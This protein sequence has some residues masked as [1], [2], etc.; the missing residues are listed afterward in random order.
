[1][2]NYK[3]S[4]TGQ[5]SEGIELNNFALKII[6]FVYQSLSVWCNDPDRPKEQAE[7]KLN[8]QLCKFLDSQ[9]R[10]EFSMIR[11]DHEEYQTGRY[12]VDLSASPAEHIIIKGKSYSIYEPLLVFE[13]KRLPAPRKDRE[14]EYITGGDKKTGGIQRFKLGLHGGELKLVAMIGYLQD[15]TLGHWHSKI[16]EWILELSKGESSDGLGWSEDEV[17]HYLVDESIDTAKHRSEHNRI[18]ENEIDKIIIYHLWVVMNNQI[19]N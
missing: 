3:G 16:N 15:N 5:I 17:L 13:G 2:N 1:M 9:T 18:K 12:A 10:I 4:S 8:L 14:Q 6:E 19:D 7:N 11:F